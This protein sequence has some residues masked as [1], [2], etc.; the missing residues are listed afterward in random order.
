[1]VEGS[2]FNDGDLITPS[3]VYDGF[4]DQR[5]IALDMCDNLILAHEEQLK[6]VLLQTIDL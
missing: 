3:T 4:Y 6:E 2:V 1:M 5:Q